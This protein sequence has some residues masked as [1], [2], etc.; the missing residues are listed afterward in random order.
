MGVAIVAEGSGS[1][2]TVDPA[3][4]RVRR[5]CPS[6]GSGIGLLLVVL[7]MVVGS[8]RIGDNSFLTHLATGRFI[9]A[10]RS[11]PSSDI[12]SFTASGDP[13]VVQSWLASVIYAGLEQTLGLGAV[14]LLHGGLAGAVVAVMWMFTRPVERLVIRV[15]LVFLPLAVGAMLWSPRPLLFGLLGLAMVLL[16]LSA[17][18][19]PRWLFAVFA[20]W[21]ATH[22]SFP[23][24]L[25]LIVVVGL[26]AALDDRRFPVVEARAALWAALGTSTVLLGPLGV[27]G[28]RF[29]LELLSKQDVLRHVVEWQPPQYRT[30]AEWLFLALVVLA[31][32]TLARRGGSWRVVLP[33]LLALVLGL[34]ALRNLSV[35]S[36]VLVWAM[37][38]ALSRPA[39]GG[40][41][42][43]DR[44]V[45][46]AALSLSAALAALTL[47]ASVHRS[48]ALALEDYP[49]EEL[50]ALERQ[51]LL[52]GPEARLLT[53]DDVGN[54]L[55]LRH[56]RAARVFIDDRVD[57]YPAQVVGD[58][59]A[60]L[61]GRDIDA[62]MR[63]W[64]PDVVLWL[65]DSPLHSWLER[66]P[67]WRLVRS[68]DDY[69][70]F[71]RS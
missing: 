50:V 70:T 52:G 28:L 1:T 57:M 9:L 43:G 53:H 21:G 60:L 69:V 38:P 31:V 56:G 29:P 63:R 47:V 35:A 6:L 26:G 55:T 18:I 66:E 2:A 68:N 71:V 22:G 25:A 17:R 10:D 15:G 62:V 16:S 36:M 30:P 5:I 42:A 33:T 67:G 13:W 14:R 59:V 61:K 58:Y 45:L 40:P 19:S 54:Y 39:P 41:A 48:D 64:Q 20:V 7:G 32:A 37:V 44:N 34:T 27:S 24:G 4:S 3:P 49:V 51:G 23:L 12:Y 8:R 46:S 11:V 65:A